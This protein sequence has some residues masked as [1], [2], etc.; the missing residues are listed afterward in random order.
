MNCTSKLVT[1][2]HLPQVTNAGTLISYSCD[3]QY[4]LTVLS[5]EAKKKKKVKMASEF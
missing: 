2:G 5:N 1:F 3:I 4:S